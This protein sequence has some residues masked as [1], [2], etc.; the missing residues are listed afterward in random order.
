MVA[1]AEKYSRTANT[2]EKRTARNSY[3]PKNAYRDF[4]LQAQNRGPAQN[5]RVLSAKYLDDSTGWYYYGFR[6][7]SPE[8]GRWPSR[9][10]KDEQGFSLLVGANGY[11]SV[12]WLY[13]DILEKTDL[14]YGFLHNNGL[15]QIDAVGLSPARCGLSCGKDVTASLATAKTTTEAGYS[16]L[17]TLAK[18]KVNCKPWTYPWFLVLSNSTLRD[19]MANGWDL[20]N[21]TR[22]WIPHMTSPACAPVF[23]RPDVNLCHESVW[24]DGGCHRAWDV[25]Y[26]LYGWMNRLCNG[27]F[28]SSGLYGTDESEMVNKITAWK[29]IS[30]KTAEI[31]RATAW[32]RAGYNGYPASSASTPTTPPFYLVCEEC[33]ECPIVALD[34]LWPH[35]SW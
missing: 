1:L 34:P 8:L 9:D 22:S 26:V 10:P 19:R 14:L 18:K 16:A 31:P 7:Y 32:A 21:M 28:G 2:E 6:Y 23:T 13:E 5:N 17:G 15:Y 4:F 27:T 24:V 12:T 11:V 29:T 25:N 35:P 30:G 3:M 20:N 33:G